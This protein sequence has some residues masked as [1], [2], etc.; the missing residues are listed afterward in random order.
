MRFLERH[1][2]AL[3]WLTWLSVAALAIDRTLFA[4]RPP[5]YDLAIYIG[6][7]KGQRYGASLYDYVN[8]GGFPFTYPP[9]AGIVMYPVGVLPLRAV[10]I[11][12][13]LATLVAVFAIA[14]ILTSARPPLLRRLPERLQLP[15]VCLALTG[16]VAFASNIKSGQVSLFL[17]LLV[18]LDAFDKTPSRLRG[19]CTGLA[20]AI[21]LTPAAFIPFLWFAGHR[22]A[23]LVATGTSIGATA[24][25]FAVSP[26]DSMRFWS[27]EVWNTARIGNLAWYGNQSL[28]GVALRLG[29]DSGVA[30]AMLALVCLAV[31]VVAYARATTLA[32]EG[33]ILLAVAVVGAMSI[34]VS[35]ISWKHHQ[36]WLVLAVF[37]LVGTALRAQIGWAA[38]ALLLVVIPSQIW[39]DLAPIPALQHLTGN[40]QAFLALAIAALVPFAQRPAPSVQK[41][42]RSHPRRLI[43]HQGVTDNTAPHE[44]DSV[45][46]RGP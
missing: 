7:I 40:M 43:L 28:N 22:R 15:L 30:K 13:T 23:A 3:T 26:E 27:T 44:V 12:W 34:V 31:M 25:T 4:L 5:L 18:L 42:R 11:G 19:V 32:R 14:W 33:E 45:A 38:V 10:E 46:G 21:K 24:L 39:R 2:N 17:V 36:L 20:V 1:T 37:A 41:P 16:S 8:D 9:F 6:A 29:F 35:P